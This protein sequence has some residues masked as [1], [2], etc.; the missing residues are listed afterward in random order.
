MAKEK[1]QL[2][3]VTRR[4]KEHYG[5]YASD[6]Y[7]W[8]VDAEGNR[9]DG[10]ESDFEFVEPL[11]RNP[12][13]PA[14]TVREYSRIDGDKI[15]VTIQEY[16]KI[17]DITLSSRRDRQSFLDD[18]KQCQKICDLLG[19]EFK[20]MIRDEP[21]KVTVVSGNIRNHASTT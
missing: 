5:M 16:S 1:I 14:S 6:W 13:D 2:V 15:H 7:V 3:E 8:G 11:Q 20:Q 17:M 10:W 4:S 18:L 9:H 19:L 12:I 21:W